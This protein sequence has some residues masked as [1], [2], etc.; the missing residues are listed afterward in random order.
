MLLLNFLKMGVSAAEFAFWAIFVGETK[1]ADNFPTAQNLRAPVHDAAATNSH[2]LCTGCTRAEG[3]RPMDASEYTVRQLDRLSYRLR[4]HEPDTVHVP[5]AHRAD[6]FQ[7]SARTCGGGRGQTEAGDDVSRWRHYGSRRS[8]THHRHA[9]L[10][11]RRLSVLPGITLSPI[12]GKAQSEAYP[13][14]VKNCTETLFF[15]VVLGVSRKVNKNKITRSPAVA[16]IA[17]RTDCQWLPRSSKV[18]DF[19][20]VWQGVCHFLLVI[21]SSTGPIF[22]RFRDAAIDRLKHFT[23]NC[24]QTAADG[25][26]VTIDSL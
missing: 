22:H 4:L 21:N 26:M 15:F 7:R 25:D 24:G 5:A 8:A 11:R 14:F 16:R 20:L 3:R 13:H 23:E 12:C 6:R 18:N 1:F 10:C 17:Y 2:K 9:H 19:Y